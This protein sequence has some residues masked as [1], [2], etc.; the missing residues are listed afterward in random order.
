M[1]AQADNILADYLRTRSRNKIVIFREKITGIEFTNIGLLI[2]EAIFNLKDTDRLSLRATQ[3]LEA[4]LQ[5][6]TYEHPVY[7][8]ILA[9]TN[10]GILLEPEL[11]ID[12]IRML[13]RY[14]QN[15]TL[16]VHWEG[17]TDNE[18]LYFLTK[19]NG[20]KIKMKNLSHLVL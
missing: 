12:F 3:E 10:I 14:S 15:N 16:F 6:A 19:E 17:D 18:H 4:I 20:R 7:G 2:S 9:I 5:K 11:K 1:N 13:D 8:K